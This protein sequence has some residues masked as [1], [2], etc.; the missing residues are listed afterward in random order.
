MLVLFSDME[1]VTGGT[2]FVGGA[3]VEHLRRAGR[4][5]RV[6]ARASSKTEALTN[7]GVEITIGDVLDRNSL[8]KAMHGV[9]VL[10]HAAAQFEAWTADPN[11]ML[12]TANEGTRNM[13]DAAMA[14]GV[15]KVLH[16]SSAAAF[17]LPR[18]TVVTE[19][20]KEPGWLID[21]YYRSKHE[22]EVIA[23]SYLSK[24]LNLITLNPSNVYGPRDLKPLGTSL[25]RFV[26]GEV[27]AIWNANFP[28]VYIEDVA[29]AH[30]LAAERGKVG[31]RYLLVERNAEY[32]EFFEVIATLSRAKLPPIVPAWAALAT[33]Q[34]AELV[35]R[36]TKKPPLVSVMQ[37]RSGTQG[38]RFDG[39]KASRELGLQYTPMEDGL[40]DALTWYWEQGYL[41]T[42]PVFL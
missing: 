4:K 36:V 11:G 22:S 13:M 40:R 42:K 34:I 30:L 29:R 18:N 12:D 41:K 25:V 24:G 35:A 39:T 31:E 3:I 32:R 27:P 6:L 38:T 21:V 19:E 16:T 2:G 17:G 26:N 5:V 9:D 10:Y 28:I 23:N 8:Q 14:A 15:S 33:A 1:L 37:V 20:M 7:A